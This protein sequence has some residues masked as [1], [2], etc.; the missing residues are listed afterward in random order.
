MGNTQGWI[1]YIALMTLKFLN[2]DEQNT[3]APERQSIGE[4]KKKAK[5]S[6]LRMS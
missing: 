6:I 4:K 1:L 2:A 5:L 3:N